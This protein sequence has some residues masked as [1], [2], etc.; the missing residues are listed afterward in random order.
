[1][2]P[3]FPPP[4]PPTAQHVT[5]RAGVVYLV[6]T[7]GRDEAVSSGEVADVEER[8]ISLAQRY[9]VPYQPPLFGNVR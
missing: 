6:H 3:L 7:D 2:I 4:S 5:T 9:D 8:A 1:M